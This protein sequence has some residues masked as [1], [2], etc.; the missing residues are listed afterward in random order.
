MRKTNFATVLDEA[1][2][3]FYFMGMDRTLIYQ[4]G[5]LIMAFGQK[6]D[7]SI[8]LETNQDLNFEEFHQIAKRMF[9]TLLNDLQG[10]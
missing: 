2:F 3:C 1:T 8:I 7:N 5:M 9:L 10:N 4:E 6:A